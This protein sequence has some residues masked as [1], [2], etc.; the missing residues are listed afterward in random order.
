MASLDELI[1]KQAEHI[2]SDMTVK[3]LRVFAK[4]EH[5]VIPSRYTRKDEIYDNIYCQ[6][7]EKR[8]FRD[9]VARNTYNVEKKYRAIRNE[10]ERIRQDAKIA[11]YKEFL[12]SL[13]SDDKKLFK[14]V[15][16]ILCF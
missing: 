15:I 13:T 4:L 6:L 14:K 9:A 8:S 10:E 5:I 1:D 16:Q 12:T 2:M 3:Q 7:I 11:Q